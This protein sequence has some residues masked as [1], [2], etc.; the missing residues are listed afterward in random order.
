MSWKKRFAANVP[1]LRLP[2][3]GPFRITEEPESLG[4]GKYRAKLDSRD[5]SQ[6]FQLTT[7]EGTIGDIV[8]AQGDGFCEAY[9]EDVD[10]SEYIRF[11][12]VE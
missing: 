4:K 11:R 2:D 6:D 12:G 1:Y 7:F 3:I 5:D 8:Y 10:G 9:L